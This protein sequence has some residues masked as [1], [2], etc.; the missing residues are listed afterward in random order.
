MLGREDLLGDPRFETP[1]TRAEHEAEINALVTDW[2]KKHDKHEAMRLLGSAGIP[3]GA[4][5]DTKE[6]VEDR[7]STSA[8]SCRRWSIPTSRTTPCRPGRCATTAS[9]RRSRPR[10]CSASIPARCSQS[11][12]GLG[13]REIEGLAQ[14]KVITQ[15]R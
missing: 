10:R 13:E 11:W 14:E 2:T 4:V 3:A 1:Q 7:P 15:R 5:L 8:A 12:L 9:R 6:L